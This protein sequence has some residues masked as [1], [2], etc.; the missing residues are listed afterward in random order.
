MALCDATTREATQVD[1]CDDGSR[2]S[3]PWLS[4]QDHR[5]PVVSQRNIIYIV[6]AIVVVLVVIYFLR[7]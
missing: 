5:R 7:T 2:S 1:Q 4:C 3:V 6:G